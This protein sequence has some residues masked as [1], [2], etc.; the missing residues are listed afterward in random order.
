MYDFLIGGVL[1]FRPAHFRKVN[2]YSNMFW[3]W[4]GEDDDMYYR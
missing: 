2:G 3:S 4:G 1:G